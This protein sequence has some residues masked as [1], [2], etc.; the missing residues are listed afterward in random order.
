MDNYILDEILGAQGSSMEVKVEV[1]TAKQS[2]QVCLDLFLTFFNLSRKKY[3]LD[4]EKL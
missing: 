1:K 4:S 2:N 3:N